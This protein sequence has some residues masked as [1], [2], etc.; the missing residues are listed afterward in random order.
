MGFVLYLQNGFFVVFLL[1]QLI[2]QINNKWDQS[3]VFSLTR[4]D[5]HNKIKDIF[6]TP[7]S[8]LLSLPSQF[9]S[10]QPLSDF[11]H[12]R[13]DFCLFLD[14]HKRNE[15]VYAWI[16]HLYCFEIHSHVWVWQSGIHFITDWCSTAWLYHNCVHLFSCSVHLC[17]SQFLTIRK[18]M[19]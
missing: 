15:L 5:A 2:W 16:L 17:H 18:I 14:S 9:P 11:Y 13:L 10:P 4:L 6:I 8:A 1:L 12:H 19:L 3:Q 7:E